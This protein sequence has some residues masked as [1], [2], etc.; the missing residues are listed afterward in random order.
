MKLAHG[1]GGIFLN[2]DAVPAWQQRLDQSPAPAWREFQA[3]CG[4]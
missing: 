2:P 1:L 4:I 3:R